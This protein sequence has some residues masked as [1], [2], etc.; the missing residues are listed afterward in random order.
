M[1]PKVLHIRS[2]TPGASPST[3]SLEV[4]QIAIN[5]PDSLVYIR[6]SGSGVDIVNP[7]LSANVKNTGNFILSGSSNITGSLNILGNT[8]QSG[9]NTLIGNTTLSGSIQMSGS[10]TQVG[11][12]KLLGDTT[13]S[14]SLIISGAFGTPTPSVKIYGDLEQNGYIKFKPVTTSID[15]ILTGSYIYVSGSTNDLYFSQNGDGYNNVTRLRW[16][17]G[18][19]YSGLLHGGLITTQSAT[20]YQVSSG[21]GLIVNLNGSFKDDPYPTIKYLN[22][23]NLSASIAPLSAS[24]DQTFVAIDDSAN[25]YTSGIPYYDG[26]YDT[27]IPVGLVLH[28]NHSTIN[29]VKT[30]PSLA[31]GF[32]QRESLFSRAFGPLKLSGFTLAPS[33]SNG[34]TS[35]GSLILSGGTAYSD[36]T[37]YTIDPNNPSYVTD[38]GT[39]TSKIWRYRQSGSGTGFGAWIYDTNNGN[40]YTT[41]DPTQ[42]S[43]NGILTPVSGS[44][45]N[46]GWSIQRV[47]WFPSSVAKSLVV[48]YGNAQY[49]TENDA[50]LNINVE[51]FIEAPNTTAN[52]IYVGAIVVRNNAVFTNNNSYKIIPGGLFRNVGGAGGGGGSVI[53]QTLAGLTD[54]DIVGP[55]DGQVLMYHQE[56]LHWQNSSYISASISGNAAT[57]TTASYALTASYLL[58]GATASYSVSSSHASTASFAGTASYVNPLNQTVIISGL[59]DLT[60]SM[61]VSGSITSSLLGTASYAVHALSS[62]YANSASYSISSSFTTTASY[63]EIAGALVTGIDI[64]VNNVTASIVSASLI[65]A[66]GSQLTN[67]GSIDKIFYVSEQ[68]VDTNDGKTMNTTFRTI[69]RAAQAA[70][71]SYAANAS[72]APYRMSIRISPGYYVE[73]ASIWIAPWTSI[74]GN[75]LRTTVVK[76]TTDTKGEN[77][78]LMNNG[79]YAWGLRFEGCEIDDLENPR[80]GFF[81]AF[82]PSASITTSPYI[83]NCSCINTPADKFYTP[84]DP[85]ANPPNPLVGNGPGGMIV[86]DSVLDPFSPLKSMIVDSY[87]QVAFNG[88]GLCVRGRGYAQQVSFF[89]NFTRVGVYAMEGGHASLL[90]SNTTFGDYG[91]RASGSRIIVVPNITN[92]SASVDVVGSTLLTSEKTAI[93]N[94]MIAGLQTNGWYSSSYSDTGSI[95]YSATMKDAGLLIDAL[96]ADLLVAKAARTST[97]LQGEFKGQDVSNDKRFTLPAATGFTKG[98]IAAFRVNDSKHMA[99]DYT[100]SYQFIKNYII[101]DPD[102][103][104]TTMLPQGKQKVGQML[105]LAIDVIRSVAIDVEPTY[106]EEFGS[107]ITSTS[108]DFSY[109]GSGVNFLGLPS[110]QGGVGTTNK[111]LR[112]YSE[113]G[114]RVYESSGDETGNFY[115]GSDFVIQ[116]STGTI[117]GRTFNKS[118]AARVVPLNLALEG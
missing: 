96:A 67:V 73:T 36:G 37:N 3:A 61:N 90:N 27:L 21:S 32:K 25:I 92:I 17:E 57:A 116:Q 85:T 78:F 46:R 6:Q 64:N 54:V 74:M 4:G 89:T 49:P 100:S 69:K 52:A 35:T 8:I 94:Y 82:A 33:G 58:G 19:L 98:A 13:I 114:G 70:S 111:E 72:P 34:G 80:K 40:G 10:I 66:D 88:I 50:I 41:I 112:V 75:D 104:F 106:L 26:Q 118:I 60:G 68:G 117:E 76:P 79:T 39:T 29:G 31:Y 93:K 71:A 38:V 16:L 15:T 95:V 30:Q 83:Q 42:Y 65:I 48:Y 107:L 105:D 56:G 1:S 86:D 20:V 63:S 103:K 44:G 87:T 110:N 84:L 113:A 102:N 99:Q 55:T 5:V 9:S 62:S 81:F 51:A 12:I 59:L 53:T 28:Q 2:L 22:W 77:L 91:L 47:Y 11:D 7:L 115:V 109:A 43:S 14:G 45:V 24:Y 97:F 23:G 101:N 18:N 108:H